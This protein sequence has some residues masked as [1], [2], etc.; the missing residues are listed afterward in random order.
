MAN[1]RA[2]KSDVSFLEE[3]PWVQPASAWRWARILPC[4][5]PVY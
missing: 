4:T 2:F 1:K 5:F 3:S